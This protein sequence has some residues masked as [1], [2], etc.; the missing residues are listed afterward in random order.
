VALSKQKN[1]KKPLFQGEGVL[2]WKI[3]NFCLTSCKSGWKIGESGKFAKISPSVAESS[4]S[5]F[6]PP[7][8]S[9]KNAV[10]GL[11]SLNP[12]CLNSCC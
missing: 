8:N 6:L 3:G 2:I 11:L 9:I 7:K 5:A 4:I 1:S 10:Q 12:L